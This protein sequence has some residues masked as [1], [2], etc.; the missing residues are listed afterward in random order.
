MRALDQWKSTFTDRHLWGTVLLGGLIWFT[1]LGYRDLIDPD[2]GRYAQI[3]AAMV[4]SGDWLT[5]RMF[6]FKYFEKP[7]LQYWAT[8]ASFLAFGQSNVSARLWTA[9]MG[10][11][12]VLL[13]VL[14]TSILFGHDAAFFAALFSLSNLLMVTMAH[15]LTLDMILTTFLIAGVGCFAVAQVWRGDPT[16]NRNWMLLGWAAL[17]LATL[18]KG[19]IGIVLPAASVILYSL[20]QR[21]FEL[22]KKLHILKGIALYLAITAP[23]FVAVS[24]KNAEFAQFFFI[25]EH[26]TRYTTTEHHRQ[27]PVYYFALVFLL[28][29]LPW[30]AT[31]ISA[32]VQ[33]D[34]AKVPANSGGFN[35]PRFLWT[36]VI[37]VLVFFSLGQS[38]LPA[39]ILPAIPI[40]A[41]LSGRWISRRRTVGADRWTMAGMGVATLAIGI[42]VT[43]FATDRNP[44]EIYENYQPWIII[45]SLMLLGG[46]YFMHAFCFAKR[47]AVAVGSICALLAFQMFLWGYQA[48]AESRSNRRIAEVIL[49][50]D[51]PPKQSF[52]VRTIP[53]SLPFYLDRPVTL[54]AKKGELA[55]G[56]EAEPKKWIASVGE[57]HQRWVL[58]DNA[59]AVIDRKHY[60]DYRAQKIPMVVVYTGYRRMVVAR[61]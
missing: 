8:A 48:L 3:P 50:L 10:F 15:M 30:L 29:V 25:H 23:W 45:G 59:V 58:L 27:Q 19:L 46:A 18:T 55:M 35:A 9:V 36:F 12:C 11:A 57:F 16:R 49:A 22:W 54:V 34:F 33:P 47:Q 31:T 41:V 6:G 1:L 13:V 17:A 44:V 4:S 28:G 5:P 14:F 21:D 53:E 52:A 60:L 24:L 43:G 61:R 32:L 42:F 56:I 38:K 37:F 26:W 20:W 40:C 51:P 39:Y 7:A 2:E